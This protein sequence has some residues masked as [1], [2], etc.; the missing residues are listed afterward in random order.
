MR[1]DACMQ[2][3]QQS[4]EEQEAILALK[5]K[6]QSMM[7]QQ[8]PDGVFSTDELRTVHKYMP[9]FSDDEVQ[10]LS[11]VFSTGTDSSKCT[12]MSRECMLVIKLVACEFKLELRDVLSRCGFLLDEWKKCGV[13][14][15]HKNAS[16]E[17][18]KNER[19]PGSLCCRCH[20][21]YEVQKA[22]EFVRKCLGG[23]MEM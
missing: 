19:K 4:S 2:D 14:N 10:K 12:R 9:L 7:V 21:K 5:C 8:D 18:C 13:R 20:G 3:L 16:S 11:N 17:L 23:E 6:L 1:M 22:E 15:K